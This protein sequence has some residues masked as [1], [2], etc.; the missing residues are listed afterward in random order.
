MWSVDG[1]TEKRLKMGRF[2]YFDWDI[3]YRYAVQL[4]YK[5]FNEKVENFIFSVRRK[6]SRKS[7]RQI[8]QY[9]TQSN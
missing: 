2:L 1:W 4:I 7:N 5:N 3:R 8:G 6:M 9:F